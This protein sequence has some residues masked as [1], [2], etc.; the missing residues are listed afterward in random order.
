MVVAEEKLDYIFRYLNS[1]LSFHRKIRNLRNLCIGITYL[2][3]Q[4]IQDTFL[5]S[6]LL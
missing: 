3:D 2:C 1:F 4:A 6:Q 5:V